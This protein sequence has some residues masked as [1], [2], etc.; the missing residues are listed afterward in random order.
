MDKTHDKVFGEMEIKHGWQKKQTLPFWGKDVVFRIKAAQYSNNEITDTQRKNYQYVL[1]NIQVI[2][3]KSKTA[4][5]AYIKKNEQDV[6]S[7]LAN[8]ADLSPEN[9]VSPRTMIFFA[10]GKYGILFDCKW[11]EHGL[12]VSLPGYE[13]GPQDMLL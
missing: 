6:K 12:A 10:D 8:K 2:S 13:V 3:G 9:L 1:D 11:D 4:I 5:G 7:G